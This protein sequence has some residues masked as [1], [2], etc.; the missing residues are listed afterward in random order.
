MQPTL[1]QRVQ[2]LASFSMFCFLHESSSKSRKLLF[3]LGLGP[4]TETS[5]QM[6]KSNC[7][8]KCI[9]EDKMNDAERS[10]NREPVVALHGTSCLGYTLSWHTWVTS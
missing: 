4:V 1:A 6:W 3:G 2:Q 10:S 7:T 8:Q 9:Y 5:I